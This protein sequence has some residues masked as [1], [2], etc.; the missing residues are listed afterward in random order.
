MV[1]SIAVSLILAVEEEREG[2]RKSVCDE[3]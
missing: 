3:F 1:R 2:G